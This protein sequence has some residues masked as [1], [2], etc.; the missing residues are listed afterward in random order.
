MGGDAAVRLSGLGPQPLHLSDWLEITDPGVG[1]NRFAYAGNSP[2]N[3]SD[4]G[5]NCPS[6]FGAGVG[7]VVGLAAHAA[8]D[9]WRVRSRSACP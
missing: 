4:P 1:T 8:A 5:G 2:V 6:C 7:A 9:V 3:L